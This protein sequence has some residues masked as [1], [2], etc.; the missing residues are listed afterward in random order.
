MQHRRFSGW[1]VLPILLLALV[2]LMWSTVTAQASTA[3]PVSA[4]LPALQQVGGDDGHISRG[5][6]KSFPAEAA[7]RWEGTW[8]VTVGGH[9]Q[10][11]VANAS[12]EFD[13]EDL[14]YAIGVC[15]KVETASATSNIALEIDS[16]SDC[17]GDNGDNGDDD[18]DDDGDNNEIEVYG[19]I[20]DPMPERNAQ[21][22]LEGQ[23]KIQTRTGE[24]LA[25]QITERT[26]FDYEH[27][28]LAV[29]SCVEVEAQ[30]A[31][32][33]VAE[34]I[35]SESAYK[36]RSGDDDDNDGDPEFEGLFFGIVEDLPDT[37]DYTGLW[38]VSGITFTVNTA[39][40]LDLHFEQE[41]L[42][43]D[44]VKVEFREDQ[45]DR[46]ATEIKL[47][48]DRRDDD[49]DDGDYEYD[50]RFGHA[51]GTLTSMEPVPALWVVAGITYSV[52]E[53]TILAERPMPIAVGGNVKVKFYLDDTGNR[54]AVRIQGTSER[55][56]VDEANLFRFV[57]SIGAM[58]ADGT[59]IGDWVIGGVTFV[60]TDQTRFDDDE[61]LFVVGAWVSVKYY[62]DESTGDLII[63]KIEVEVPPDAGDDNR[64][65]EIE[66]RHDESAASA[67]LNVWRIDG[68]DYVVTPATD[69]D[70]SGVLVLNS[71]ALVNSYV[72]ADGS[73]VAT[74]IAG[75][76]VVRN[77]Y[78]PIL[79]R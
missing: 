70:D 54:I 23:L 69:L 51:W 20:L 76:A 64:L 1:T 24:T 39:T 67:M 49:D 60:T 10:E 74:R 41:F 62:I 57:S 29:G 63:V 68:A 78:L 26:Q 5:T 48:Y 4:D 19:R 34:K 72:A 31:T 65:G 2:A 71:T 66:R 7:G 77:I 36:C 75:V 8:V 58:P 47:I 56:E 52:T 37:D 25:F 16:E 79:G 13:T 42:V 22:R 14:A 59:L 35:E 55:G 32:P 9:D 11:F 3:A 73:N 38:T 53:E 12:T 21:G 40:E 30:T 43:G 44:Y 15:V 46:V 61:A 18:G 17:N 45:G 28:P 27:G 50:W 6:I 33:T